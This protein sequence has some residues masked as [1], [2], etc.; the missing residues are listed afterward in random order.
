MNIL[1]DITLNTTSDPKIHSFTHENQGSWFLNLTPT[2]C[3]QQKPIN[4]MDGWEN[5][6]STFKGLLWNTMPISWDQPGN[7]LPHQSRCKSHGQAIDVMIGVRNHLVPGAIFVST[8][9]RGSLCLVFCIIRGDTMTINLNSDRKQS[10]IQSKNKSPF[11]T[12]IHHHEPILTSQHPFFFNDTV[13]D[14]HF[15]PIKKNH[16]D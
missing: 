3:H 14:D 2:L 15:W 13:H 10:K 6:Q 8:S 5:H 9:D 16:H 1:H 12:T 11:L 7:K 4:H